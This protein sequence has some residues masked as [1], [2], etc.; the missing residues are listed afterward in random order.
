MTLKESNS[1]HFPSMHTAHTHQLKRWLP[2]PTPNHTRIPTPLDWHCQSQ[3]RWAV[4]GTTMARRPPWLIETEWLTTPPH[5]SPHTQNSLMKTNGHQS[6]QCRHYRLWG[7]V[8]MAAIGSREWLAY[9][10]S[11]YV[12]PSI[13]PATTESCVRCFNQWDPSKRFAEILKAGRL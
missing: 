10:C 6:H 11:N 7:Q 8:P 12:H 5:A 13:S 9:F 3:S 2:I 1:T 4:P